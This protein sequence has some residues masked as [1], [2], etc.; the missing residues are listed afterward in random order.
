[1]DRLGFCFLDRPSVSKQIELV[2]K[3]EELGFESAWVTE[4][5]LARDAFS[6]LGAFAAVTK[7]IKLC[8]GIVN[9]W[10]RGPALLAMTLATLDEFAP[11]RVICGLGAYWDPLAWKQGIERSKPVEQMREY[12]QAVRRLLNLEEFTYEGEFVKL[13]NISLD[14]GHGA[15]RL[16]KDAKLYI[17]P[18]GPV[19]TKLAGEIADGAIIN[20]LLSPQYTRGMIDQLRAG[21]KKAGR[22]MNGFEQ[23]QLINISMSEDEKEAR[24]ISRYLVTKYLGQQPHIGKAAGLEPELLER[25]NKTMGGWP[26]KPGGI[27]EAMKLVSDEVTDSLTISGN[28]K[29][30]KDR[31]GEWLDAGITY[32]VILPLS[33]N[34][35]EMVDKLA[36]GKW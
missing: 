21:A 26:A 13:R 4:T 10:T 35:H 20:G 15:P 17:G 7:R 29:K 36:P 28:E 6:V 22:T 16:P 32:P 3:I 23:P 33:E 1:M 9:S 11:G 27:E 31:M 14:L 5:R 19:M 12:L 2:K 8:T 34:Y 24:E 25:I 30:I 18:T